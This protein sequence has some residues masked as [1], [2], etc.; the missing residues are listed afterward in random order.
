MWMGKSRSVVEEIKP[1]GEIVRDLVRRRGGAMTAVIVGR[2]A[3]WL[4]SRFCHTVRR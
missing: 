2:E 1:A 3:E 4:P